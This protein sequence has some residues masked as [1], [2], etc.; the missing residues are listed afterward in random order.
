MP[1]DIVLSACYLYLVYRKLL[2]FFIDKADQKK[3][4]YINDSYEALLQTLITQKRMRLNIV[5]RPR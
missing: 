2:K 5:L 4:F 3:Q 1:R